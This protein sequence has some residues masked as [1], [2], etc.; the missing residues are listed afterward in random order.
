MGAY[1]WNNMGV[2]EVGSRQSAVVSYPNPTNGISDFRF[3][4]SEY[5]HVTLKIYDVNGRE[6]AVVLDENMLAG[7][8]SVRFDA[9]G[10]PA[11]VYCYRLTTPDSLRSRG[12]AADYRLTT[13]GKLV[14]Y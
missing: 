1:E 4:I 8:H 7:E 5:Q 10:L 9:S 2:P 3:Q 12:Q 14:I 6:V 11:G 13:S